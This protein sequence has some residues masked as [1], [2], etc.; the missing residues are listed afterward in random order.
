MSD[1][2][3]DASESWKAVSG[4][5]GKLGDSFKKHYTNEDDESNTASE[6]KNA[7]TTLGQGLERLFGAVGEAVKDDEVK[8][9]A[10]AAGTSLLDALGETFTKAAYEMRDAFKNGGGTTITDRGG[11]EVVEEVVDVMEAAEAELDD[12]DAIDEIRADLDE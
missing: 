4:E 3:N 12:S 11:D 8:E 10:K 9:S 1:W 6:V 5:F 7:L 2:K